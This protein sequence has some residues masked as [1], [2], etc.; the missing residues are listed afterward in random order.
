[1]NYWP[2][3]SFI[4]QNPKIIE[5]SAILIRILVAPIALLGI[6]SGKTGIAR[7]SLCEN[8]HCSAFSVGKPALLGILYEKTGIARHFLWE[9]RH[10]S[11]FSMEKASLRPISKE[12][13]LFSINIEF[14]DQKSDSRGNFSRGN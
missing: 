12:K 2:K 9:N 6:L 14:L 11:A 13:T 7:H 1:L 8:R 5:K 4:G 3:R 10:C